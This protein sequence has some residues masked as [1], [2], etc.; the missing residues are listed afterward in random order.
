MEKETPNYITKIPVMQFD[1]STSVFL[2]VSYPQIIY[3][4]DGQHLYKLRR[5]L[6]QAVKRIGNMG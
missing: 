4:G 6:F 3:L 2:S 5:T 1:A